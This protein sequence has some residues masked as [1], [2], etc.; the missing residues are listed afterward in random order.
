LARKKQEQRQPDQSKTRRLL[1]SKPQHSNRSRITRG[2]YGLHGTRTHRVK[3]KGNELER[4]NF[5]GG[6]KGI[7]IPPRNSETRPKEGEEK[8]Q[9]AKQWKKPAAAACTPA[10]A[11]VSSVDEGAFRFKLLEAALCDGQDLSEIL[12]RPMG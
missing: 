8:R 6:A 3:G 10:D 4:N 7:E 9:Q 12:D 2:F 11:R 1:A 5:P